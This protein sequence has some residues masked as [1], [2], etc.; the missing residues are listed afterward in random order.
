MYYVYVLHEHLSPWILTDARADGH[1]AVRIGLLFG[2]L[3]Q[4][5][6]GDLVRKILLK[7]PVNKCARKDSKDLSVKLNLHQTP[8]RRMK[9]LFTTNGTTTHGTALHQ[10]ILLECGGLSI[11]PGQIIIPIFSAVSFLSGWACCTSFS[12]HD[13]QPRSI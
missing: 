5:R 4:G 10:K 8:N 12:L 1:G 13:G 2:I 6:N 3:N 7:F 11:Y 9:L